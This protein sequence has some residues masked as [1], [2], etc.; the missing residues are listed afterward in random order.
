MRTAAKVDVNN[1][2][3]PGTRV[4]LDGSDISS[5]CYYAEQYEDGSGRAFCF[6]LR[7][8]RPYVDGTDA[9][10]EIRYGTVEII[11]PSMKAD[12]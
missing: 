7:N 5:V 10:I 12:K 8:G 6:K 2:F 11:F 1:D 4:N 3:I 9:A